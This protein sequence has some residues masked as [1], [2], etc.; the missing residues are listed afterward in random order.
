MSSSAQAMRPQQ[1]DTTRTTRARRFAAGLRNHACADLRKLPRHHGDL[2]ARLS[3][4]AALALGMICGIAQAQSL[5]ATIPSGSGPVAVAVNQT[6]NMVYV[7][8]NTIKTLLVINGATNTATAIPAGGPLAG[9]A[10]NPTTNTI[11]ALNGGSTSSSLGGTVVNPGSVAVINGATNTV[12]ATIALPGLASFIAVNPVTNHIYVSTL[13][14]PVGNGVTGNVVVI[15]GSTNS[16]TATV[17]M[18]ALISHI[19]VDTVRNVMYVMYSPVAGNFNQSTLAAISGATNTVT[20]TVAVGIN[21]G[22]FALNETTNTI[23]VPDAH[24]NLIYVIDGATDTVTA[25]VAIP[26]GLQLYTLPSAVNPVTDKIYATAYSTSPAADW[27]QVL[28]GS[29]NALGAK[30]ADPT[31]GTLL[32]N[33]VTNKIWQ[34][35]SPVVVIDGAANTATPVTGTSGLQISSTIGALNTTTNYAYMAGVGNVFV[36]SGAA[37]G[38]AFSATPTPLAFGN[39]TQGTTSSAMTL[40]VTNT[41]TTDLTITTVTPGGTNMADFTIGTDTCSDATV[42]AGKTCTVS[43]EFDPTTTSSESATLTFADNA[44]DSPETV[45]LTGT[46]VAPVAT[47]T[48]TKLTASSTSA[49]VGT[50]VTFTATVTPATGTPTPTGTV[51]F[52]DGATTLGTGTLNGSGVATYSTSSLALGSHSITANYGGD[53]RNT[54]S[55]SSTIT[56]NVTAGSTA[57]ALT[58]SATS[59][60]VGSS[61]TFTATVT[62]ASGVPAPT[63]TVTFVDG[64]TTL[65]TGTLNGSGVA[66]YSSSA[67]AAGSHSVT[68]SYAGDTNNAASISSAVAVSVWPGS[69]AFTVTLSPSSGSFAAGTPAMVTVTVTSVNGFNS[70]AAL[71][72]GSLPQNTTCTFSSTSITPAVSGTATSTLTIATDV[73]ASSATLR[74][75]TSRSTPAR[76]PFQRPIALAGALV[77]FLLFP[78]FCARN[79]KVRRLLLAASSAILIAGIASIG[80]NGCGGSGPKTPTGIYPIQVTVTSGS[81]TQSATFSLTIQ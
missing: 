61:V 30:I 33:P 79:R 62:G 56:V 80:M 68:A 14:G 12:T 78:L 49:A 28:D 67:L 59:I 19:D 20:A 34:I 15:D 76:S 81:L 75:E 51:T 6:T 47:P 65:G 4:L 23:Y 5:V 1:S 21:D 58:A 42:A 55:T 41:G 48:T 53:A 32:A 38:P 9:V 16:I 73:K 52:K 70:A 27:V 66:T 26:S 29:T 35:N 31:L 37:A 57:T 13:S 60:V 10:V 3:L 77:A 17:S 25:Q 22:S 54:G 64:T 40:T 11:Y 44:S 50:S 7:A 24:F 36:I 72:C 45:T 46:G 18:T 2:W 69:A 71:A 63:G 43:V 39:Q 8:D 74:S